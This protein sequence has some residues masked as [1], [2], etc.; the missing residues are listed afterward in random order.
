[1]EVL[2]MKICFLASAESYHTV[3]WCNY[4]IK[5][6]H[7]V[8]VISLVKGDIDNTSVYWLGEKEVIS[9]NEFT[10][11]SYIR[12][13]GKI[14]KIL[15]ELKPDIIHSHYVSSYGLLGVLSGYQPH[16]T[17]AWGSDVILVPEKSIFHKVL[18]KYV[19][20]QA[21]FIMATSEYMKDTMKQLTGKKIYVT[22]FGIDLD[23]FSNRRRERE[24]NN[25]FRVGIVK[26]LRK[27]YGIDILINAM[28]LII[29]KYSEQKF[30]LVIVG[31][32]EEE[33]EL[34]SLSRKLNI[35]A[36]VLFKG[37][38]SEDEVVAELNELDIAVFPS[39]SESFGVSAIE[40][41]AC[42]VPVIISDAPGLV[43]V[44]VENQTC[45]KFSRGNTYELFEKIETLYLSEELRK[46]FG[47]NGR[48]N[49]AAKYNIESNF[50]YIEEIYINV[51][52]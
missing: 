51:L 24:K 17:S 18:V 20:S 44:T 12:Y 16:F 22:P 49:V 1:M 7:E 28:K 27:I 23:K 39:N 32:G 45:L 2:R 4:F 47:K 26:N 11:I 33:I 25:V 40:A 30:E 10:K 13:I 6:G 46:N 8:H 43:E 50:K 42:E 52:L 14:K 5:S 15:D 38:M 37:Y 3:K 35:E 9:R 29:E 31:K 21:N 41:Q 36:S 34:K 48:A 19:L